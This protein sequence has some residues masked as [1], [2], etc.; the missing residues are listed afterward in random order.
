[1]GQLCSKS[2]AKFS[3]TCPPDLH[4][5]IRAGTVFLKFESLSAK[6]G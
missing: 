3:A 6:T 4:F 5:M 2:K 1:M